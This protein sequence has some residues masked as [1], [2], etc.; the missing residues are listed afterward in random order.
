MK[1]G[2]TPTVSS[3]PASGL[4]TTSSSRLLICNFRIWRHIIFIAY[5]RPAEAEKY[6]LEKIAE[7]H[8]IRVVLE[9]EGEAEAVRARGEA[10][11]FAAL[12]RAKA[13]AEQA[14]NKAE[15]WKEYKEA[16]MIE[17]LLETLPKVK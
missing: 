16:A 8:R 11:A 17:M 3:G 9:A 12:A 7:A 14:A 1:F 2:V 5:S 13:E 15:A 6:R 10:E 4:Y